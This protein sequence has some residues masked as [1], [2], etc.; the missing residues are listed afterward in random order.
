MVYGITLSIR[1]YLAVS[2]PEVSEVVLMRDGVTL[3]GRAKPFLSVRY[4]GTNDELLAAGRTSYE[5]IM[6][7]QIGIHAEDIT[8]LLR[9]ESKVKTMLR[10]PDGIVRYTDDAIATED[11]FNVDVGGFTPITNDDT[12]N[13]TADH[14]GYFDASVTAYLDTGDTEFTQ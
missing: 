12:S 7:Y 2:M 9:L 10:R 4:L 6:R 5:E 8:Q 11:R 1:Q 14:R 13:T 3:T